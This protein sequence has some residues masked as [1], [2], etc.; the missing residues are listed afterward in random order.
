MGR[1]KKRGAA[2]NC[3][4]AYASGVAAKFSVRSWQEVR[5]KYRVIERFR[6]K[7][8][9]EAMCGV[10]EVSRSGYYAW[11]NRQGRV[12][13]DQWLINLITD[14]Q[15]RC[16]QTYGC[17][18][19]RRWIQHQI[20][21][22]VNLKAILRIMRKYDLLTQIRRRRPYMHYKQA[23]HKYHNLLKRDFERSLPNRF[24]VTDITYIPTAKG[25]AYLCTVVDLCGKMVLSYRVGNDMTALLVTD[26]IRDD[27][28]KREGR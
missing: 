17:R 12:A 19:V 16:K 13:K 20:D 15:Q 22:N 6:G 9:V 1:T 11:R 24:W 7:Y 8:S 25:V 18:R 3:G 2:M 27:M 26:T 10:F 21:K 14:Y 4:I 5:L 28:Q 23:T